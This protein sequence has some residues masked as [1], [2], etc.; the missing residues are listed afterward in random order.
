MFTQQ[1]KL[2]QIQCFSSYV[3]VLFVWQCELSDWTIS[4]SGIEIRYIYDL[5]Q[6]TFLRQMEGKVQWGGRKTDDSGH[7]AC[8]VYVA[9]SSVFNVS[10]VRN[11]FFC[12]AWPEWVMYTNCIALYSIVC[13]FFSNEGKILTHCRDFCLW[14]TLSKYGNSIF[15]HV[16]F[17]RYVKIGHYK[18]K[19]LYLRFCVCS[20]PHFSL[21]ESLNLSN[22][23]YIRYIKNVIFVKFD[24][25]ERQGL[26]SHSFFI[27]KET[28]STRW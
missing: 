10:R 3:I 2:A 17:C 7:F 9:F 22:I 27:V 11:H 26:S 24:I 8:C 25:L 1:V 14:C 23:L 15:F 16:Y 12:S 6:S 5:W 20:P 4:E 28:I 18:K 13:C 19:K 21:F